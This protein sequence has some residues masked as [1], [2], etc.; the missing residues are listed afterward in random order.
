MKKGGLFGK[1]FPIDLNDVVDV[2]TH[3]WHDCVALL[4]SCGHLF[5]GSASGDGRFTQ[6]LLDASE[7]QFRR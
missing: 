6:C 5:V 3:R 4:S 1:K 2:F 7:S